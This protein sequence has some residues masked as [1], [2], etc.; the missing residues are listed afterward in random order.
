MLVRLMVEIQT[1]DVQCNCAT[2]YLGGPRS[3][4]VQGNEGSH[5][6]NCQTNLAIV[7]YELS[8]LLGI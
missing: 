7:H 8:L 2:T 6:P 4:L 3:S 1:A 5:L